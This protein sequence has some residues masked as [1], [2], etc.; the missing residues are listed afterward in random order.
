MSNKKILV[1][2]GGAYLD[3]ASELGTTTINVVKFFVSPEKFRLVFFTGGSD[4]DPGLYGHERAAKTYTNPFRDYIER[5]IFDL[6]ATH[7]I[8][9]AGVCRGLQWLT[10]MDGG[11]MIQH[12]T[13][14]AVLR[15]HGVH[16]YRKTA[17]PVNSYHHQ[18]V[19]PRENAYIVCV[20]PRL[21][22]MYIVGN[23]RPWKEG[24]VQEV[25]SAYFPDIKAFGV[26]W[27]PE[28]L[29]EN[30]PARQFFT[31]HLGYLLDNTLEEVLE[32]RNCPTHGDL[33]SVGR[34]PKYKKRY[35]IAKTMKKR[36][37]KND[38]AV[39]NGEVQR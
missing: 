36:R 1:V 29:K 9:M 19:M 5:Q 32:E 13:D 8:P 15:E 7:N 27:H 28:M 18:M 20:S 34:R 22:R 4:V 12:T 14:H 2:G 33:E 17:F 38:E 23:N 16:T 26:Q 25:E 24:P 39:R 11:Y 10:V 31:E 6:A 30:H 3:I 35:R 37:R 21:S